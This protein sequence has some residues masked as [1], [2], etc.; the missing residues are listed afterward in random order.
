M[1]DPLPASPCPSGFAY[2]TE[3]DFRRSE[4]LSEEPAS[5]HTWQMS[6]PANLLFIF[7]DEQRYDTLPHAADRPSAYP[8]GCLRMPNLERFAESATVFE[9]AYCTQP[10]CTPSRGSIMTGLYPQFHGAYDNNVPLDRTA[11]TL[12]ELLPEAHR[13]RYARA[14]HG[15]W[16]LGDEIFAQ[17]GFENWIGYEDEY[18]PY[19][20]D[21]R[22]RELKC[23]Y[24]RWLREQGFK[25]DSPDGNFSRGRA[26]TLPEAFSK[27]TFIAGETCRF[28]EENRHQPFI[29]YLNFLEPHMPFYGPL[30][31]MYP[32]ESVPLPPNF[33]DFPA[34]DLPLSHA[35]AERWKAHGFEWYDLSTEAGWR[36]MIAAYMGLNTLIDRCVGSVLDKLESLGLMDETIIVFTSD[37]GE[38]MGS[39]RLIGKQV[40]Y[41]ESIRV[42]LLIRLPGQC[43]QQRIT[44][45]MSQIDLVPTLLDL[46]GA[47]LPEG[48][49]GTSKAELLRNGGNARLEDDVFICWNTRAHGESPA[50]RSTE[51]LCFREDVRTLVTPDG[52]RF[53]YF[54]ETGAHELFCLREDPMECHNLAR[55]PGQV[56]RIEGFTRR[57]QA[58]EAKL[59]N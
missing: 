42:P 35:K 18:A 49:H 43:E 54:P 33:N 19:Y 16:H 34:P 30:S 10:V 55:D 59:N 17:H 26:S 57:L 52:W 20:S 41:Q 50:P 3:G 27:A 21:G 4:S 53:S 47:P 13:N 8:G 51:Q 44:G 12:P 38:M 22:D 14:Y 9:E 58:W 5:V 15:K 46:I 29:H 37:H 39:H 25:P 11:R 48:L 45:P 6:K 24:N 23:R 36:Q 28:L 31:G 7:T 32:P 56:A 2:F 40:M 1:A